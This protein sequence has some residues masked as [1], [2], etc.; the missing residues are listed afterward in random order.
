MKMNKF[1][2]I[3]V[4]SVALSM[5][6]SAHAQSNGYGVPAQGTQ[7]ES[8]S[9]PLTGFLGGL[10]KG[11]T[12]RAGGVVNGVTVAQNKVSQDWQRLNSHQQNY[13]PNAVQ[14]PV[15]TAASNSYE[16]ANQVNQND[17]GLMS[18]PVVQKVS[19]GFT[20]T[21]DGIGNIINKMRAQAVNNNDN[22]NS[23]T[24]KTQP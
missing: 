9:N 8:S 2:T 21:K 1:L 3:G 22:T 17:S 23:D 4:A 16:Q 11:F 7:Q 19:D 18:Q 13:N 14:K 15:T 12:Q 20:A 24:F 10:A 6:L 5:S